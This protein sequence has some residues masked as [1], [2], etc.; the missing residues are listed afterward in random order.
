[1]ILDDL[2]A[3]MAALDALVDWADP[4]SPAVAAMLARDTPAKGWTV[5]D[6]VVHLARTDQV[7]VVAVDDPENFPG[8]RRD[9]PPLTVVELPAVWPDL[10]ARMLAGLERAQAEGARLPWVSRPMGATSFATARLMEYWAHGEDVATALGRTRPPT[11]RLRNVCH[12]GV[13]TLGFSFAQHGLPEPTEPVRVE[14]TGPDGEVWT[15]GPEDAVNRVS[16]PAIHF[17]LVVTQRRL[18]VESAL[19]ADGEVA[20]Q[21]LPIAQCFAGAGAT[22][23]PDRAGLPM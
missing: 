9:D 8:R 10:R 3:E 5:G 21:W 23:D 1:M 11:A 4:G 7:S 15:W 18:A 13:Q 16:G 6:T 17:A 14:L 22:T 19:L 20:D 12:I 2:R